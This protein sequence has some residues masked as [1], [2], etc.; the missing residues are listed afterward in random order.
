MYKRQTQPAHIDHVARSDI[1]A[2]PIILVSQNLR[3]CHAI[4]YHVPL[5]ELCMQSLAQ[6][7]RTALNYDTCGFESLNL[8][9]CAALTTRN[10]GTW[11]MSVRLFKY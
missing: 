5:D 3:L 2:G 1:K 10:D 7:S 11:N 6:S 9:L 8:G 4:L